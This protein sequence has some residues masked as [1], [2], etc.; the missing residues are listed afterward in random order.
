GM[1]QTDG[2][3]I[4]RGW[5]NM[6]PVATSTREMGPGSRRD[7]LDDHF[8]DW[9]WHKVSNLGPLLLKKLKAIL[10]C[11]QHAVDLRDFEE[12]IPSLSLSTWRKMVE[13]WE[14]DLSRPNP[15]EIQAS[16]KFCLYMIQYVISN[17]LC[18]SCY[19]GICQTG[20]LPA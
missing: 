15:F 3:A 6:N 10:E 8:G 2:E 19:P 12:V 16:G 4:E 7:I 18:Y 20:A 1:A 11:H 17:F 13:E 14:D 9:N 5:S